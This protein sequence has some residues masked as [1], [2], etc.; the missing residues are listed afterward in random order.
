MSLIENIFPEFAARRSEAKL[1][2]A[3]NNLKSEFIHRNKEAMLRYAGAA[4]NGDRGVAPV[5]TGPDSNENSTDRVRINNEVRQL[6]KDNCI[7]AG[8]IKKYKTY[9]VG[10][11]LHYQSKHPSVPLSKLIESVIKDRTA[12]IDVTGRF[13]LSAV[14][15]MIL[16]EILI[17]D[18]G[19]N[20]VTSEDY[21]VN[22]ELIECD[23]IGNP[24][25]QD[26]SETHVCGVNINPVTGRPIS[27]DIYNRGKSWNNYKFLKRIPHGQMF[28][29]GFP[30]QFSQY[31]YVSPLAPALNKIKDHYE[32]MQAIQLRIKY[33]ATIA[34]VVTRNQGGSTGPF[35]PDNFIQTGGV[36]PGTGSE[37]KVVQGIAQTLTME[38]G[39][40]ITSFDPRFPEQ[41]IQTFLSEL[42]TEIA[43]PL[44][45]P[46]EF[47]WN[48]GGLG[49]P[50]SRVVLAQAQ[51]QFECDQAYLESY[52]LTPLINRIIFR[53]ASIG[54]FGRGVNPFDPA[55]YQGFWTW[56]QKI[57]I[58]GRDEK[59]DV[60]LVRAQL[61]TRE[62]YFRD[63]SG[64]WHDEMRQIAIERRTQ[65]EI[66]ADEGVPTTDITRQN[67]SGQIITE[68]ENTKT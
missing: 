4:R 23:R 12:R 57:S 27:Y 65:L 35:N 22:V 55:L 28:L 33:A 61:L 44:N 48:I 26:V 47:I 68:I 21:G 49:G 31:R 6:Q 62:K 38:P 59:T 14:C 43:Q 34:A 37:P 13:D 41:H 2:A 67:P 18:V 45:L 29:L 16:Q 25:T 64:D 11:D 46:P 30:S 1:R 15:G 3:Q 8:V 54:S 5:Q 7:V 51:R 24:Y 56:P 17:G 63:R 39:E 66:D 42:V 36:L 50:S 60:E 52:F 19:V 40:G 10:S 53:E 20:Y 9:V 32:T 58:D